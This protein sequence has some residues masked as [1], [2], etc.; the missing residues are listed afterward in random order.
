MKKKLYVALL[1]LFIG[2]GAAVLGG[3]EPDEGEMAITSTQESSSANEE[4]VQWNVEV[5]SLNATCISGEEEGVSG[6]ETYTSESNGEVN[7]RGVSF[8]GF[9]Q[10]PNPC[11]VLDYEVTE[12]EDNVYTV[13]LVAE[14]DPEA[15]ICM[16]CVGVIEYQANFDT[17]EGFVLN[18]EHEGEQ[19]ETIEHE[20]YAES[21]SGEPVQGLFKSFTE[22]F[23]S[24]F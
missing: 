21:G 23:K 6:H 5:S 19:V 3:P 10:T 11:Y 22:W 7:E 16:E 2:L 9:I 20:D 13:D 14:E 18:I 8:T 12:E 1:M 15:E 24:F 4:G 17:T